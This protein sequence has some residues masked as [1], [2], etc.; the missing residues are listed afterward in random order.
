MQ[1]AHD[2]L[3]ITQGE[4]YMRTPSGKFIFMISVIAVIFALGL[5]AQ[6]EEENF[7]DLFNFGE[8]VE[9]G[10]GQE[11]EEFEDIFGDEGSLF[12]EE[13]SDAPAEGDVVI[14]ML[15]KREVPRNLSLY[16]TVA[17]P[18]Y[19]SQDLM[20]WNSD[21]DLRFSTEFPLVIGG[22]VPGFCISDFTFENALPVGGIFEGV[23]IFGT[24]SRPLFPGKLT[25]GGGMIGEEAGAFA[26]QSYEFTL[27]GRMLIS[28]DFRLTYVNAFNGGDPV[29]WFD[30]GI[31]PGMI[32]Y[33]AEQ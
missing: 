15:E 18:T 17:S 20:T 13:E 29:T 27:W 12:P 19:V 5:H 23:A 1:T 33:K 10:A 6:E 7:D 30:L 14:K 31:S 8:E 2:S 9:E 26:Q 21:V 22:L 4:K 25:V 24:L 3:I 28:A 11:D 16:L 32:I